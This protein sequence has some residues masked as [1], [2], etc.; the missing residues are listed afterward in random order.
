M[1]AVELRNRTIC[2]EPL[3]LA[4][5]A[6]ASMAAVRVGHAWHPQRMLARILVEWLIALGCSLLIS[7]FVAT[8]ER[9][10]N[11]LAGLLSVVIIYPFFVESILKRTVGAT[12]PLELLI[13]TSLQ[14]VTLVLAAFSYLPRLSGTSVLLGSFLLL[15]AITMTTSRWILLLAAAY[16]P[17]GLWWLMNIYWQPLVGTFIATR[18]ERRFPLRLCV[19]GLTTIGLLLLAVLVVSATPSAVALNGFMPTSGGTGQHDPSA[20]S[21]LGDGDQMVA[22]KQD[23]QS[24]GPVESELFLEDEMPTLYD[25]FNEM[26]GEP[27]KKKD[28]QRNIGLAPDQVRETEQR[29]AKNEQNGR[30]FSTV[31][32][33]RAVQPKA[34]SDLRSTAM[35]Y[36]LGRVPLHLALARYDAFDGRDWLQSRE[37]QRL[38]PVRL[39]NSLGKPWAYFAP[40]RPSKIFCGQESHAIKIIN[41]KTNRFPSPPH[42]LAVHVDKVDQEDFFGWS[43]DGVAQMPVRDYIPQLT[44]LHLLSRG[45]NCQELRRTDFTEC[46]PSPTHSDTTAIPISPESSA[47]ESLEIGHHL[48][49]ARR[50]KLLS[51]T[52]TNWT[53]DV[54]RGWRQVE[55]IVA[56]LRSNFTFDEQALPTEHDDPV[57]HFL[58][59]RRGPDYL[60]ATTA[61]LMLRELGYPTRFVTGFYA[62]PERYEHRSGQTAVLAEDV[63]TWIEVYI[64]D[65]TWL[66]LEPTP[67]YAEPREDLTWTQW[68]QMLIQTGGRTIWRQRWPI[69]AVCL[70][71]LLL[72][73]TRAT[74]LDCL[75]RFI[76]VCMGRRSMTDRVLW[77]WRLIEFRSRLVG[78]P[79]P[80]RRTIHSWYQPLVAS[81]PPEQQRSL[82]RFFQGLDEVLYATG[83][84]LECNEPEIL[85]ACRAV[86]VI[87]SRRTLRD[88]WNSNKSTAR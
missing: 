61:A 12:E 18:V 50:T 57:D 52:A 36:V 80:R 54:P 63:H 43:A 60:F 75:A 13:L 17:L 73:K 14:G 78:R 30:E 35:L 55:A 5:L 87:G 24:F 81:A 67:G 29:V 47:G 9:L 37:A 66:P 82:Q 10:L 33:H 68:A 32:K 15:F 51:E 16:G 79:R 8:Y 6:S 28:Q 27:T 2:W 39:D 85:Q 74:W 11:A 76:C 62:R 71:S 48:Q 4:I 20:R 88:L 46:F 45:V 22:A 44:V 26:N 83:R 65:D 1:K 59:V 25:M 64:G 84:H 19:V 41:I 77:T 31:R 21:G 70:L 38:P 72:F 58:A 53:A 49:I 42:L 86:V 40:E 7:R 69:C 23:A 56:Y 34:L 3:L